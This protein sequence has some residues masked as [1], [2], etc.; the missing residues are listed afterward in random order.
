MG[1]VRIYV[2]LRKLHEAF[3][4]K[5]QRPMSLGRL[6]V[7][8]KESEQ[9]IIASERWH[10]VNGKLVKRFAFRERRLRDAFVNALFEYELTV[11]HQADMFISGDEVRLCVFTR[12]IDHIT[13]LDREYARFA[14]A[15]FKDVV[16]SPGENLPGF[17]SYE[18]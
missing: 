3:I 2:N 8:A 7:Q 6:P 16:Y 18:R 17:E 14:D 9:P 13:E 10:N 15:S 5:A 4:E 1:D 12:H 11:Q